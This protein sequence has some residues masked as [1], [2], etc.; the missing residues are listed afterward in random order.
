MFEWA[1]PLSLTRAARSRRQLPAPD[2]RLFLAIRRRAQSP[3]AGERS[4][5]R[6]AVV[7][8][9]G[10]RDSARA[11]LLQE[12]RRRLALQRKRQLELQLHPDGG[13]DGRDDLPGAATRIAGLPLLSSSPSLPAPLPSTLLFPLR[14]PSLCAP[15]PSPLPCPP[16]LA[17]RQSTIRTRHPPRSPLTVRPTAPP[18]VA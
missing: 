12:R 1:P 7:P 4:G 13:L 11:R 15:L 18:G 9:A 6:L 3:H 2:R 10:L 16:P 14:S 8:D 17:V 5:Q